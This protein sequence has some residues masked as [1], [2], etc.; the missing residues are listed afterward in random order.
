MFMTVGLFDILWANRNGQV[1]A[2]IHNKLCIRAE[3]INKH[4]DSSETLVHKG[5]GT[6]YSD[7]PHR[8]EQHN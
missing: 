5:R 3:T 8:F 7:V 4:L 2:L 1:S 6:D